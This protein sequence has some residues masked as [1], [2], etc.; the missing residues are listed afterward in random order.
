MIVVAIALLLPSTLSVRDY[1]R[2]MPSCNIKRFNKNIDKCM[3]KPMP[4][5][6]QAIQTWN[7]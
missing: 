4:C 3:L 1:E 5:F 6:T 7:K 2:L